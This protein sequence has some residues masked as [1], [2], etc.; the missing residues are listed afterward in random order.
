MVNLVPNP[1]LGGVELESD[2]LSRQVFGEAQENIR[3][4][5]GNFGF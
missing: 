1:R 5:S 4:Q 2:P 3:P